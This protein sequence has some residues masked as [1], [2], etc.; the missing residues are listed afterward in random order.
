[1][2]RLRMTEVQY[3]IPRTRVS[4]RGV[5]HAK[6]MQEKK[7]ADKS[8]YNVMGV[9]TN[10][11]PEELKKAYRKKALQLHPDKRGNSSVTQE[12]VSTNRLVLLF[13]TLIFFCL[14]S[15]RS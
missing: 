8:Y 15:L 11:S 1:M 4:S 12:E 5:S 6:R 14:G 3:T 10:V 9:S 2:V 13:H 7:V